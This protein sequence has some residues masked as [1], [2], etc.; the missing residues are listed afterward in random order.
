VKIAVTAWMSGTK[1]L[2]SELAKQGTIAEE[3]G[4]HSFWLPENHF[5]DQRS[6]P[7][8]L[9]LLSAV[10]ATTGKIKLGSTSYLLPIRNPILAAEEVA[11]LDRLSGGRVI[12]GVGRGVQPAMFDVFDI[13]VKEKRQR[14]K[15]NLEIMINAWHGQPIITANGE[16]EEIR[17]APL[18]IQTPHPPIWVAAF[19]PLAL[20]QAGSLGLPYL[21][22]PV[23]TLTTLADNYRAHREH[24]SNAG[25]TNIQAVPVMRTLF[26]S[27][28][29][30]LVKN[31]KAALD[32]GMGHS[33]RSENA[34]VDDW[35]IIGDLPYVKDKISEYETEIGMTHLIVRGQIPGISNDEQ[36]ASFEQLLSLQ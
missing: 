27:Q 21:A 16:Q 2:A 25:V 9:M 1:G 30:S 4:F 15:Q 17:L 23:E 32:E 22:S 13:P 24:A 10:A 28:D 34:I 35:T 18:P 14:F 3:M 29:K 20:K 5:G 12:L 8:P 31:V 19:G 33:M 6:L 11:V 7:A 26:V 36:L